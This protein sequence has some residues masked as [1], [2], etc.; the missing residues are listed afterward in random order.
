VRGDGVG[1][2]QGRNGTGSE[3]KTYSARTLYFVE[4]AGHGDVVISSVGAK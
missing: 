1:T 2:V 4:K 3:S